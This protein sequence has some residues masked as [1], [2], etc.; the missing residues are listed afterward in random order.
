MAPKWP[1]G[2]VK[3][4]QAQEFEKRL[5]VSYLAGYVRCMF[6]IKQTDEFRNW[7]KK[8]RDIRANTL[9]VK[10]LERIVLGNFGDH[11]K[12]DSKISELR[13]DYEPGYRIFYMKLKN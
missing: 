8:L 5:A 11:K 13:I 12:I 1:A 10:R 4:R 9:I 6:L 3:D 2:F 7:M